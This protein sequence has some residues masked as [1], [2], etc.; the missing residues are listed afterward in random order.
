MNHPIPNTVSVF[1]SDAP[2]LKLLPVLSEFL[3]YLTFEPADAREN[4]ILTLSVIP[5][6]SARAEHFSLKIKEGKIDIQAKDFRGLVNAAATLTQNVRSEN[7]TLVLPD[8]HIEEH[9][10][11]SF[12]SFMADPARNLIPMDEMRALILSMAKARLNK[13]HLHMSDT[14]GFAYVSEVFPDLPPAPGGCYSKADL[15]E[16]IS[17]AGMFGIDIIP[18]IDVPG[19]GFAITDWKPHLKCKVKDENGKYRED[20]SGWSLCLGN[21]ECYEFLDALF[22]ELAEIF[23][24]DYIHIGTD[25]LEL[26]TV[27][28]EPPLL[29]PISHCEECECCRDFF[30]PLG[31]DNLRERFYWF[32]RRV[33]K[34]ITGLG[35]KMM[36]WNDDI[37]IAKSPDLPRDILIEFWR[38]AAEQCGPVEGCS[39]QRFLEEGFEVVNTEC[40]TTYIDEFVEWNKLKKWH[41]KRYPADASACEHQV[42]GGEMCAW[43]GSNYP[44]YLYALY[45]AMPAF[46]SR[47]WNPAPIEDEDDASAKAAI[48]RAALG[49]D[50]PDGFDPFIY[51]KD[52]EIPL[53]TCRHWD[54]LF[55]E[56]ANLEQMCEVLRSL[57]H[58]SEDQ[59]RLTQRLIEIAEK[60]K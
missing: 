30:T 53:G 32:V 12:R 48:A 22:A 58:Q 4:S 45:F 36:M 19:H 26:R 6:I 5:G 35:K 43:E 31:L 56:G 29:P 1:C 42:L 52:K 55:A 51:T 46:G 33:Y 8:L 57:K 23:P 7:G 47:L 14:K 40:L 13:L 17:Y 39:M 11:A 27:V 16:L 50:I 49:C 21:S 3:P 28:H 24:Y 25:E 15:K 10:D 20:V 37:D 2:S 59:R 9:P 18:E 44:H 60:S 41:Y 34:T 38:V 54:A